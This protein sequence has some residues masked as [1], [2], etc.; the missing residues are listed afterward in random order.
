MTT[1]VSKVHHLTTIT[2]VAKDLGEDEDRLWDI[3]KEME[4]EDGVTYSM[5]SGKTASRR[6]PVLGTPI[7]LIGR[8]KESPEFQGANPAAYAHR[9]RVSLRWLPM[10]ARAAERRSTSK[11]WSRA[12]ELMSVAWRCWL[13]SRDQRRIR[14]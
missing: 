3:T 2:K 6:L 14:P 11:H 4:I 1:H 5:A 7:E 9:I 13:C 12:A 8:Y 10:L